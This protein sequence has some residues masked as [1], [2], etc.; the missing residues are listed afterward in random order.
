M[1]LAPSGRLVRFVGLTALLQAVGVIASARLMIRPIRPDGGTWT[2]YLFFGLYALVLVLG[3]GTCTLALGTLIRRLVGARAEGPA[4]VGLVALSALALVADVGTF[5]ILGVHPYGRA[6]WS[7]V[8]AA[9]IRQHLA[10]WAWPGA[11]ALVAA[12]VVLAVLL[13]RLSGRHETGT[14]WAGIEARLRWRI[15]VYFVLGLITFHALDQPDEERVVPR[16][17]LPLYGLWMAAGNRF[18]DAVPAYPRNSEP[19]APVFKRRPDIAVLLVESWRWDIATPEYMPFF[20]RLGTTPGCAEAPRHYAG[21]HLTQYGAFPLLYGLASYA[22][23]PF[24]K[25]G[26]RSAPLDALR[27]AGYRLEGYDASGLLY[28]GTV[29]IDST[30]FDRYESLLG[31]DSLVVERM[32]S[33][34][35]ERSARPRFV[36]GFLYSTHGG[37]TYPPAFARLQTSGLGMDPTIALKNR[38]RNAA[39][40]VDALVARLDSALAPRLADGRAALVVTGDHAEEFWEHGILGHAADQFYDQETR[41]PMLFCFAGARKADLTLSTHAD[42]LPTLFDWM[43]APGW[44]SAQLTGRSLLARSPYGDR[45]VELSGAGFPT[46]GGAFALVTPSYKFW[47][48]LTGPSLAAIALDKATDTLDLPV[49]MTAAVRREYDR[50]LATYLR[51]Q[52]AVLLVN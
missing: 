38:Y 26:R 19:P 45:V 48:H 36:F 11:V 1:S 3:T 30:Q 22:F 4:A 14:R 20:A 25:Q 43:G 51:T 10:W 33:T 24:M 44:D 47:L 13:W 37:Y 29:P 52:H 2:E 8:S 16:A 28:Y 5:A 40:Y 39:G 31:E 41:V 23:L 12:V 21:G 32:V 6:T 50:A 15:P 27:A 17:A 49:P 7:A 42:I 9:D 18:P 46:Q 34:L 35:R